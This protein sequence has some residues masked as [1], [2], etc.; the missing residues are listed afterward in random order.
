MTIQTRFIEYQHG[1]TTLEGMLAW[2]DE[3]TGPRP[4]VL[5]AHAWSG[6]SDFECDKAKALAELGYV[7]FAIDMFGKGVRGSSKE[8]NQ[9]LIAPFIEN[10]AHLQ[11]RISLAV[12]VAKQQPE[13]D[14][15]KIG[16]IGFCFGGLCVLDLARIGAD[17]C[18]VVSFHGLFFAPGNTEG[19]AITSK[20]L[21]LHGY[22][23]PMATPDQMTALAAELTQA[24]ADWQ[25]HAYGNTL[26]A[27]TNPEANDPDFGTV[28][29]AKAEAR[30]LQAMRNFFEE[31]FA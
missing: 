27:F 10:R 17:V 21:C 24:G 7:G 12:D 19:N 13:T 28:Y 23:D 31:A 20:V 18:G 8:E 6:R 25:I 14:T 2:N 26:H 1:D 11:E 4:T 5:V 22:D 16:A 9:G 29:C 30:S 15:S 3:V